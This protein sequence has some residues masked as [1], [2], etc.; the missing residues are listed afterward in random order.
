MT[1]PERRLARALNR[2]TFLPGSWDKRFVRAM[3]FLEEHGPA[4]DLTEKQAANL[5]RLAHKYRRQMP[6]ALVTLAS[7]LRALPD[8][9]TAEPR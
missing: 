6:P 7:T 8:A 5:A 9:E 1:E 4:H 3:A 2:C